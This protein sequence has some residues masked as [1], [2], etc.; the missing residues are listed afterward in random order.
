MPFLIQHLKFTGYV[1]LGINLWLFFL[2]GELPPSQTPLR[3]I[4]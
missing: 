4:P 1:S 2:R 3:E